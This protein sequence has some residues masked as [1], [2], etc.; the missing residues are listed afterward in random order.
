[1]VVNEKFLKELGI[2]VVNHHSENFM[3]HCPFHKDEHPSFAIHE[4]GKWICFSCG[5]KGTIEYLL[6][7][8]NKEDARMIITKVDIVN[9]LRVGSKNYGDRYYEYL[10]YRDSYD[11]SYMQSRGISIEVANIFKLGY[12]ANV[13][14]VIFPAFNYKNVFVGYSRR[15]IT[16]LPKYRHYSQRILFNENNVD[17]DKDIM[18]VEGAVDVLKA[19]QFG[20]TNVVGISGCTITSLQEAE[21]IRFPKVIL[22]LDNDDAG[23]KAMQSIGRFLSLKTSVSCLMYPSNVKDFGELTTIDGLQTVPYFMFNRGVRYV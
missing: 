15:N 4:N 10:V 21:L 8:L 13:P 3:C 23:N 14:A 12:D 11:H 7:L 20:I 19:Y 18:V 22:A 1:M 17:F 9:K 5:K 2:R 16:T 6:Q